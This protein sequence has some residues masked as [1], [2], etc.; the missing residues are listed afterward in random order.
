M[1]QIRIVTCPKCGAEIRRE[2]PGRMFFQYG[3]PFRNCSKCGKEYYDEGYHEMALEHEPPPSVNGKGRDKKWYRV[4]HHAEIRDAEEYRMSCDRLSDRQ[5]LSRLCGRSSG[6]RIGNRHLDIG[7]AG[8]NVSLYSVARNGHGSSKAENDKYSSQPPSGF[9]KE[10]GSTRSTHNL[11][12]TGKVGSESA[13]LGVLNKNHDSK[14][15]A[16][17]Q[18][19]N[20]DKLIHDLM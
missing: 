11:I 7:D 15:D 3:S 16:H 2:E 10:I 9:L 20:D 14:Q 8:V 1:G 18:D 12:A 13:S 17:Y 19:K 4:L 5:Y 6:S